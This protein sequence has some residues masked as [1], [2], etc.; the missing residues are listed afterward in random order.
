MLTSNLCNYSNAY[1]LVKGT[2]TVANTAAQG[3]LDNAINKK[4]RFKHLVPFVNWISRIN[5]TQVD[6]THEIDVVMPM[7][8]LLHIVIF[9]QKHL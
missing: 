9:I 8:N 4:V 5:N 2:I 3:Q 6:N 1:I 7:Y